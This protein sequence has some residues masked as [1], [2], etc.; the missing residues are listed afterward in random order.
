[1]RGR[2]ATGAVN[3]EMGDFSQPILA[4]NRSGHSL[5][6]CGADFVEWREWRWRFRDG[7]H[8]A[9]FNSDREATHAE[10]MAFFTGIAS[11]G[12]GGPDATYAGFS[13]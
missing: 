3:A 13:P 11:A 2:S 5:H 4:L 10:R 12:P 7:E 6:V 9:F 8:G 1:M